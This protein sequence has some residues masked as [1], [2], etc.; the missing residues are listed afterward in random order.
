MANL[1]RKK[2]ILFIVNTDWVAL[3]NYI[4]LLRILRKKFNVTVACADT[5]KAGEFKREDVKFINL[6]LSKSGINIFQETRSVIFLYKL[7]KT[8]TFDLIFNATLKPV[9]YG[10][11][12]NRFLI[13][14]KVI[15]SIPGLGYVFS[16]SNLR[17]LRGIVSLLARIGLNYERNITCFDN[18]DDM[19]LFIRDKLI[20]DERARV[21]KISSVDLDR[22][23]LR[24]EQ[25]GIPLVV[26]PAR[27]LYDKGIAEFVDASRILSK[28][29]I[30]VRFILIGRF[31]YSHPGAIPEEKV[32][33]WEEKGNI[34][35]WGFEKD[36]RNV[37]SKARIVVLPSYREGTGRV[38]LEAAASGIPLVATD[39]PGCR[40]VVKNH[41]TGILVPARDSGKL[42]GAIKFLLK[43]EKIRKKYGLEG[44][45]LVE[46]EFSDKKVARDMLLLIE[47]VLKNGN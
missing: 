32:R 10:S 33:E 43:S 19:G 12:L 2:K 45:K 22:F 30:G 47:E 13:K 21:C 28:E 42:A 3:E 1:Y 36:M 17:I 41:K 27:I 8:E 7:C 24:R 4:G 31:D 46:R 39:V 20:L 23:R 29:G 38:L 16:Y 5:G 18:K 37:Y 35:Y 44:R 40:E 6:P 9:I 15:N 25:K 11:I 26:L 14:R 34:E